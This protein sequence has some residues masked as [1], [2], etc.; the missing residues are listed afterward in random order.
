MCF[1]PTALVTLSPKNRA[2]LAKLV[3]P[4]LVPGHP[5]LITAARKSPATNRPGRG[6]IPRKMAIVRVQLRS[7]PHKDD[8][9]LVE[10]SIERPSMDFEDIVRDKSGILHEQHDIVQKRSALV[11]F[12]DRH[13]QKNSFYVLEDQSAP[14]IISSSI[15]A[16]LSS[17]APVLG[18]G[19]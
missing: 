6:P 17:A 5:R 3:M 4:G 2:A 14:L 13:F 18:V 15:F 7:L 1:S 19:Q 12:D 11:N 8:I 9:D 10:S 16:R